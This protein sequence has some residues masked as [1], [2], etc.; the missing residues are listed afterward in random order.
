M[1]FA[2]VEHRSRGKTWFRSSIA[3][4][5]SKFIIVTHDD[6]CAQEA[7][8]IRGGHDPGKC[9]I[10]PNCRDKWT[11]I[12]AD[13]NKP[14]PHEGLVGPRKWRVRALKMIALSL[15]IWTIAKSRDRSEIGNRRDSRRDSL[16]SR[17]RADSRR[18]SKE[19]TTIGL[20]IV[21]RRRHRPRRHSRRYYVDRNKR[22]VRAG[23]FAIG[24]DEITR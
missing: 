12:A 2:R 23:D 5:S 21:D 3:I 13:S 9:T 7:E 4:R 22:W 19:T 15:F 18:N 16:Y 6:I 14:G 24:F 20:S 8:E 17:D 10:A 1:R 11:I